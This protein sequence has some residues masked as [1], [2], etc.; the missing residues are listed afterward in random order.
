MPKSS[1][2]PHKARTKRAGGTEAAPADQPAFG[3]PQPGPDPSGF[4]V[5]HPSDNQLYNKVNEKL[6]QPFPAPR[7]L[8]EPVLTLAEVWGSSLGPAKTEAITQDGQIVF[9]CVGDTGSVT[10]PATESLVADAAQAD[11]AGSPA[12]A[13]PAFFFHL[14]DMVYSF[15]EAK[16]YYDQFY[17]PWRAYQNPIVGLAGN[18]DGLVYTGDPATTLAAWLANFCAT[19]TGSASDAGGLIRTTMTQPGVF[20]TFDAP[21]VRILALYSNVLED[22]GVIS[23]EGGTRPTLN[24]SQLTFLQTALTRCKTEKYAGAVLVAVHHPPYTGGTTHGG[25][26]RMLQ[27]IDAAASAAGFE[28]HA[29]LSGHAHNYQRFTRTLN[30]GTKGATTV[31]YV[32]AGNGG[33]GLDA[34]RK[35]NGQ[36]IRVP[37]VVD[38]TLTLENYDDSHYGFLRIT[39]D[40]VTLRI[41]YY[42][43][44]SATPTDTVSVDI[45]TRMVT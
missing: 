42:Q 16:Y 2:S 30:P 43:A 17:E 26:P 23:T 7:T 14:G 41:D 28:P 33:H 13:A 5:P 35:I 3:Q 21:F 45:E 27:D 44:G 10:G 18:H 15:G 12:N 11:L 24:D 4:K 32:V 34:M 38:D 8:P 29:V 36:T 9:H 25:S 39:V 6:V 22:P 20:Y 19:T 37:L 1:P 31:P 40:P